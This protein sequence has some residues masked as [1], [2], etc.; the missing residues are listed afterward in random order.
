VSTWLIGW[1][2]FI[3]FLWTS[4]EGEDKLW[5]LFVSLMGVFLWPVITG[6]YLAV[7]IEEKEGKS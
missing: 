7:L 2:I 5:L 6:G 1:L 3:G 4:N